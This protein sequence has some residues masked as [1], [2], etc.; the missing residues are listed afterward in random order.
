[1]LSTEHLLHLGK[2][3]REPVLG[4]DVAGGCRRSP[5]HTFRTLAGAAFNE[6]HWG[7]KSRVDRPPIKLMFEAIGAVDPAEATSLWHQVQKLQVDQGGWLN[8][9]YG[10]SI[11][12]RWPPTSRAP[13]VGVV[14]LE[15]LPNARWMDRPLVAPV[16]SERQS[17][18]GITNS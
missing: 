8:W 18:D 11:S 9:G 5:R 7:L 13:R 17:G 6:T 10:D 16:R 4:Q 12:T 2:R 1:M 15:Q 14:Q 3:I